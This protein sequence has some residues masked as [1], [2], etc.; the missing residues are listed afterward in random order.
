MG[1]GTN[2]DIVSC[3]EPQPGACCYADGSCMDNEWTWT[4]EQA[5][6]SYN[7]DGTS[8]DPNPCPQPASGACCPPGDERQEMSA[9]E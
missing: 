1:L 8:C 4:C 5:G 7:G 3:P 2:C 9:H 6:G